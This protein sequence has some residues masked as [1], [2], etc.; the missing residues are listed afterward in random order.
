MIIHIVQP[1]ETIESIADYYGVNK[2]RL[3]FDNDITNYDKL[4]I[5]QTILIVYPGQVYIAKGGDTNSSI[6]QMFGIAELTLIRNNSF[7]LDREVLVGEELVIYYQDE[8]ISDIYINGYAYPYIGRD[9]LRKSLLYLT[10]L[11]I[12]SYSIDEDGTLNEIDDMELISMAR[13]FGV[14]PVMVISGARAE[15]YMNDKFI[16]DFINN[17]EMVL[18]ILDRITTIAN[19]KNY[20]AVNVDIPYISIEDRE[21]F[22]SFL[23]LLADKLHSFE[24][25]LFI[26]LTPNSF[27]NQADEFFL[28]VNDNELVDLVDEFVLLSYSWGYASEI[29]L[30]AAP[31]SVLDIFLQYI[32]NLIPAKQVTVGF[33]SIGYI[34]EYPPIAGITK[35]S[36]IS[37]TNAVNLASETG[38]QIEFNQANQSSYFFV[39]DNSSQY[40]VYFHDIRGVDYAL[41]TLINVGVNGVGIWNVM[42]YLA[43]PFFLLN[44]QYNIMQV[45]S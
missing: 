24:I 23:K 34:V 33:S 4:A 10:Y 36:S 30:E 21:N 35:A 20:Y 11:S 17:K 31:V 18:H 42:Y 43:Q 27:E 37:S 3:I 1:G 14:A 13:S 9:I 16:N 6:A 7:L 22:I 41:S 44:T 45:I 40:F 39:S 28:L 25:K 26:T 5:G 19:E 29:P 12:F 2:D 8:K 32:V 38:A 15:G